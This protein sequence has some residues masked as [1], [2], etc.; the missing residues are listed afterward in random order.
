MASHKYTLDELNEFTRDDLRHIIKDNKINCVVTDK[1]MTKNEAIKVLLKCQDG[2][3]YC[4]TKKYTKLPPDYNGKERDCSKKSA[5][6]IKDEIKASSSPKKGKKKVKEVESDDESE[7]EKPKK[8]KTTKKKVESEEDE[9][10]EPKKKKT[11]KKKVESEEEDEDEEEPKKKKTSKKQLEENIKKIVYAIKDN[12][13][14]TVTFKYIKEK[15]LKQNVSEEDILD[16]K[17]LIKELGLKYVNERIEELE[18]KSEEE[19]EDLNLDEKVKDIILNFDGELTKLTV[20]FLIREL[21]KQGLDEYLLLDEENTAQIKELGKKYAK[22]LREKRKAEEK[23]LKLDERVKDIILNFDGELTKLTVSFLIRELTKQGLDEDLLVE[24]ENTAQIKELGKKYAKQL[25]EKRKAEEEQEPEINFED[26]VKN[27]VVNF[28][29]QLSKLTLPV[30]KKELQKEV[31]EKQI[32]KN[33]ELIKNLLKVNKEEIKVQRD[34]QLKQET[35]DIIR[36]IV[37]NYEEE[38][39]KLTVEFLIREIPKKKKKGLDREFVEE[40]RDLIKELGKTYK[41]QLK[42]QY[43]SLLQELATKG[44][45]KD[46]PK[47]I[48]DLRKLLVAPTCDP[49]NLVFCDDGKACHVENKVCID[50]SDIDQDVYKKEINGNIF[51]GSKE[52]I[53][54]LKET[55]SKKPSPPIKLPSSPLL[56]DYPQ[57]PVPEPLLPSPQVPLPSPEPQSPV[58]SPEPQVPLPSPVPQA[59]LISSPVPQAPIISSP[60]PQAPIISS[61]EEVPESI[62]PVELDVEPQAPELI[63]SEESDVESLIDEEEF[64]SQRK[65]YRKYSEISRALNDCIVQTLL[66]VY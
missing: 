29:G 43:D 31:S 16:N 63:E 40:N 46:L 30:V 57:A 64:L 45:T 49:E 60:V 13:E 27:I 50:Q 53:K 41:Q 56:S 3:N 20:P 66:K 34:L 10:E 11:I 39:S 26:K 33:L 32:E 21:A 23:D 62:E 36:E 22:Q 48:N 25:R 37:L 24:E 52:I 42:K 8:K 38:L 61:Q 7:E 6:K 58:P 44:I 5:I 14:N 15:L 47:K 17:T 9:D 35:E 51:V 55:L 19:D 54:K 4:P 28:D 18:D 12:I 1:N 2:E 65:Q 59:P